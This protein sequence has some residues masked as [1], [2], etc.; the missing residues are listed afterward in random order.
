MSAVRGGEIKNRLGFELL[1]TTICTATIGYE[2]TY[3]IYL[4][5]FEKQCLN[6]LCVLPTG[7]L[8]NNVLL[9]LINAHSIL[10]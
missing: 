4:H 2:H 6:F 5:V 10:V 9:N 8:G 7:K 1:Y 3:C